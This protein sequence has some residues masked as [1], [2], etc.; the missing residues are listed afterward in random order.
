MRYTVRYKVH[1]MKPLTTMLHYNII[2]NI[3][4]N[5]FK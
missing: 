2:Y 4:D 5:C 1:T 3:T